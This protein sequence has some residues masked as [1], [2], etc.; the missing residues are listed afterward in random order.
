MKKMVLKAQLPNK[1]A[2][3]LHMQDP[4][5][6]QPYSIVHGI[7]NVHQGTVHRYCVTRN[8]VGGLKDRQPVLG[9]CF[10]RIIFRSKVN[11]R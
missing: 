8:Y 10:F 9:S 1:C 2:Y 6:S 11:H 4:K 3:E 5:Q 7:S